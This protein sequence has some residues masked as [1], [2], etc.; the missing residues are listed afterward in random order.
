MPSSWVE[1]ANGALSKLGGQLI[2]S[3]DDGTAEAIRAK[4]RYQ[5]CCN[6][7]LRRHPWNCAIARERLAP[8][9]ST[10]AFGYTAKFNL[11]TNCLRVLSVEG[12][13]SSDY[14]IE[15]RAILASGSL[16]DL[17]Y[18][19]SITDANEIDPCLA[20]AISTY[21][22]YDLTYAFNQD[23]GVRADLLKQFEYQ[24]AA[25]RSVDGQENG[26]ETLDSDSF[27]FE[28]MGSPA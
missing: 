15:G 17:K 18:I 3:F 23:S 28:Y 16:L 11:P 4:A 5:A 8:L 1:I 26:P 13:A 24:L 20:E 25:A 14:Q 21:L 27:L 7:V 12:L 22:A 2:T 6:A 9:S 10:P 19:R